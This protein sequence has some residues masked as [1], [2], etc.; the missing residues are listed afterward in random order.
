MYKQQKV[1]IILP[2]FGRPDRLSHAIDSV[3]NQTYQNWELIVVDDNEPLSFYRKKTEEVMTS[4]SENS[5]IFYLKHDHNKNGS[6]A[7]NTGIVFSSGEYISFLDDDDIY[8]PKRIQYCVEILENSSTKYGGVYTGCKFFRN[9]HFYR[10]CKTAHSGN[11]LVETLSTTFSSYSGSNLF[12]KAS[13]VKELGGFDE[14]F[15]RHQDYEFLVRF[16]ISYDIIGISKILLIKNENG[17]NI[18]KV[19]KFAF[20]KEKYLE[21]YSEVIEELPKKMQ[22]NIYFSN[23]IG[24]AQMALET[25]RRDLYIDFLKK[26]SYYQR[27]SFR[28][29][30]K[31]KF[32][33]I[34][35]YL[36][37][38]I[39]GSHSRI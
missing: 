34:Y 5:K 23:F 6:A 30:L 14:S 28:C 16:F 24:L 36:N 18:P 31:L 33:S 8:Y 15:L 37:N 1:S 21:K 4:Y 35:T 29:L 20:I 32:I 25:N 26:A 10:N 3:I 22:S 2:T 7:R 38:K 39:H 9:G 13:V 11:Y 12:F 19:D 17:V 27:P